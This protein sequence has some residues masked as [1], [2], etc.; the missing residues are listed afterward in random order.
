MHEDDERA[1]GRG[2]LLGRVD[3]HGH[4]PAIARGDG[5]RGDGDA[6]GGGGLRG[7]EVALAGGELGAQGAEGGGG[8]VGDGGCGEGF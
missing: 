4:G 6:G 7:G 1:A 2:R 8:E 5:A 3:A